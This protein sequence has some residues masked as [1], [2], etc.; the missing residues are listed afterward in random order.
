MRDCYVAMPSGVRPDETGR[1]LDFEYLYRS[2]LQP[3]VQAVGMECRRLEELK[4]GAIWHKAMFTAL[5]SSAG[6]ST[7]V[8]Q[9]GVGQ[10]LLPATCVQVRLI[11]PVAFREIVNVS[12]PRPP[13]R[14]PK[15]A[16]LRECVFV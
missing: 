14:V 8:Y 3:A 16:K 9:S 10:P 11:S 2:V 15:P 5:I 4:P 6:P 1:R 12:P 13:T 7:Y